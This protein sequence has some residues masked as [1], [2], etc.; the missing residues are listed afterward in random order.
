[1]TLKQLN[2]I[3]KCLILFTIPTQFILYMIKLC[4][5]LKFYLEILVLKEL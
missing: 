1:M 3:W 4:I 2:N 5:Y